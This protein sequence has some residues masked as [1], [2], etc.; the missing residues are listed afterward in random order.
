MAAFIA[1]RLR[2]IRYSVCSTRTIR[3][4]PS[5]TVPLR[6][7]S[8]LAN[9]FPAD[10]H[11]SF[12]FLPRWRIRGDSAISWR[13]VA[14]TRA[15]APS[16][17]LVGLEVAKSHA[18]AHLSRRRFRLSSR[19]SAWLQRRLGWCSLNVG[20]AAVSAFC[21]EDR[22]PLSGRSY[23]VRSGDHGAADGRRGVALSHRILGQKPLE[24]LR[25]E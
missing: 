3:R 5:S 6:L 1:T 18:V 7:K 17:G 22:L 14:D 19:C 8:M 9:A 4:S 15:P 2:P 24:V 20:S 10:H 11:T 21:A 25:E 16:R 12:D 23:V 13:A